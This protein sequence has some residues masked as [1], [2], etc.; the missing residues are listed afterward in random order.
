MVVR[1][2]GGTTV[3]CLRNSLIFSGVAVFFSGC[4]MV[5]DLP[6]EAEM[7]VQEIMMHAVCE[8]RVA[9]QDMALDKRYA[10]FKA[11]EWSL[12]ITLTP[13]VDTQ[14]QM[15]FG[16]TG[17]S[18]TDKSVLRFVTWTLGT[19]PGIRVDVE[20]H[21]DGAVTFPIRSQQLLDGRKYPIYGCEDLLRTAHAL[22]QYLGI[23]EWLER[24]VPE[25]ESGLDKL[26]HVDK[27]S[28]STQI[29]VKLDGGNAGATF[30]IPNG[31][32]F[33]PAIAGLRKRDETLTITMTPD[34]VKKKVQTLPSGAIQKE[35]IKTAG[36]SAPAQ[37][38]LD[39]IELER[40]IQNLRL[41]TQ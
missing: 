20:G 26:T 14:L 11:A 33:N 23:R 7:P 8:L 13:K 34:P 27:P 6:P 39:R 19:S 15:S 21:R 40:S 5:P 41:P 29:V 9:F 36:V 35:P 22:S 30:F 24:I 2:F 4:A 38:R 25:T 17:K 12:N 1:S 10:S 28:Y 37:E 3:L 16:Y 31:A 18:T 32:T